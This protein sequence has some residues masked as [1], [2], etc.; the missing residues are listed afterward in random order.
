[1]EMS[2][3]F[4][5]WKAQAKL[6]MDKEID[7]IR[8]E[9][10][11]RSQVVDDSRELDTM[12]RR[13]DSI[14]KENEALRRQVADLKLQIEAKEN[15]Q[16]EAIRNSYELKS[17]GLKRDQNMQRELQLKD[18]E[19]HFCYKIKE[20]KQEKALLQREIDSFKLK[21]NGIGG[22]EESALIHRADKPPLP[23]EHIERDS[24]ANTLGHYLERIDFLTG[25]NERLK[26]QMQ[27][28]AL[29][30]MSG[31]GGESQAVSHLKEE[32][33][34]AASRQEALLKANNTLLGEVTRMQDYIR[35]LQ[36][37]NMS[38]LNASNPFTGSEIK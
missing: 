36:T 38:E 34:E 35:N 1:M 26:V 28:A 31:A 3:E 16:Q 14:K 22:I 24:M 11:K 33:R 37:L 30:T 19:V 12:K 8:V 18:L 20:L 9:A 23:T 6:Q 5:A 15:N 10:L 7:S 2:R 27:T 25:E 4:E 13:N 32:L 17:V 29:A 21:S